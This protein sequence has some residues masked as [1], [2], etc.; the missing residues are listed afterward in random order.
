MIIEWL[1][2]GVVLWHPSLRRAILLSGGDFW[3]VEHWVLGR[4]LYSIF[5]LIWPNGKLNWSINW[6]LE[7]FCQSNSWLT[8]YNCFGLVTNWWNSTRMFNNLF[9]ISLCKTWQNKT[10][11]LSEGWV[12]RCSAYKPCS[13]M[14]YS[15]FS[16]HI[17]HFTIHRKSLNNSEIEWKCMKRKLRI[18][19]NFNESV[20]RN[21]GIS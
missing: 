9:L 15:Q 8:L 2:S 21:N 20:S 14:G 18:F 7:C 17:F 4:P 12:I 1:M 16:I 6:W 3:F 5:Q 10:L 11:V 19:H 13:K